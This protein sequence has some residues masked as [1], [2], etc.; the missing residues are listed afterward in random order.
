MFE[1]RKKDRKLKIVLKE[2]CDISEVDEFLKEVK[3][4]VGGKKVKGKK[5]EEVEIFL[6]EAT[7]LDTSFLQVFLSLKRSGYK[8]VF[9]EGKG[10]LEV[11]EALYGVTIY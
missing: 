8:L 11:V 4:K 9:P 3:K 5:I 1:I 6:A 7:I 2:A 10:I